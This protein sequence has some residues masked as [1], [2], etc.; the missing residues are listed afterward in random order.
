MTKA[1]EP[2]QLETYYR[3]CVLQNR[4]NGGIYRGRG[5]SV[6]MYSWAATTWLAS[7]DL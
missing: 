5:V 2:L 1:P 4:A 7:H 3:V 6:E